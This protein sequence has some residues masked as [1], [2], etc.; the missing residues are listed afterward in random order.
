MPRTSKLQGVSMGLSVLGA[1]TT[2]GVVEEL[3]RAAVPAGSPLGRPLH[4]LGA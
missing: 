4:P 2:T 3:T 1:R